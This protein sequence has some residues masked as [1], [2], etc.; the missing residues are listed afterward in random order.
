MCVPLWSY[1]HFEGHK[2]YYP[3]IFPAPPLN[4]EHSLIR[5]LQSCTMSIFFFL[6]NGHV[7][8][9]QKLRNHFLSGD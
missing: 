3:L 8:H 7:L 4:N 2:G 9:L 1:V 5:L 6:Y